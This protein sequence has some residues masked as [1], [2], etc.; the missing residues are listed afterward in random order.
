MSFFLLCLSE[1]YGRLWKALGGVSLKT[2]LHHIKLED[3][4]IGMYG[5]RSLFTTRAKYSHRKAFF[6]TVSK[7][8]LKERKKDKK[9]LSLCLPLFVYVLEFAPLREYY[10]VRHNFPFWSLFTFILYIISWCAKV[11]SNIPCLFQHEAARSNNYVREGEV[12]V[13]SFIKF[14]AN[15]EVQLIS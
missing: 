6:K 5:L 8:F 14:Y 12:L 2:L 13:L 3:R 7:W 11:N 1:T 9:V 10:L 15:W 4:A